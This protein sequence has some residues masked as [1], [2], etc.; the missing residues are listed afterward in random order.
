MR[1]DQR[2]ATS[3]LL[4]FVADAFVATPDMASSDRFDAFNEIK[5]RLSETVCPKCGISAKS[6][7]A[8]GGR[9]DCPNPSQATPSA[10][11]ESV[12]EIAATAWAKSPLSQG[13]SH[14]KHS[15]SS[16]QSSIESKAAAWDKI[17]ER[18][19][20]LTGSEDWLC[21]RD[22][23][24]TQCAI[25]VID[26]F[27]ASATRTLMTDED[28]MLRQQERIE[29]LE[30]ELRNIVNAERFNRERFRNDTEFADWAV[31][32]CRHKLPGYGR[33]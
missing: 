20:E 1:D 9:P 27:A 33:G 17:M 7:F 8:C 12:E 13:L 26:R 32:R 29:V 15:E 30:G 11:R 25:A 21:N 3:R 18:L 23:N 14:D 4:K 19:T 2:D 22:L 24:G 16:K 5:A 28:V 6:Y 31:S 10:T